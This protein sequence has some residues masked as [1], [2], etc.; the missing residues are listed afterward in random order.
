M[1]TVW[2]QMG[3]IR[4]FPLLFQNGCSQSSSFPTAGQGERGSG[5]E[6]VL[7]PTRAET[8]SHHSSLN[9]LLACQ[10]VTPEKIEQVTRIYVI[11]W[12]GQKHGLLY[13]V[14]VSKLDI[15]DVRLLEGQCALFVLL[16]Q[17]H[18][19]LSLLLFRFGH[20]S[21]VYRRGFSES[22]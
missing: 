19:R 5:N 22:T 8:Y 3:R 21:Q 1:Q 4:L 10:I 17:C 9:L 7:K 13:F 15:L 6:I 14:T 2:D 11:V 12:E 18:K 16:P 20:S